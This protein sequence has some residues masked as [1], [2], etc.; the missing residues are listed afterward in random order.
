MLASGADAD[1]ERIARGFERLAARDQLGHRPPLGAPPI[2]PVDHRT[3]R[4]HGARPHLARHRAFEEFGTLPGPLVLVDM[5]IGAEGDEGARVVGHPLGDV[6]VQVQGHDDRN[7]GP[8]PGAQACQQFALAV[9]VAGDD[10][11]AVQVQQ[12]AVDR[13]L[14]LGRV[15]DHAA[16][17]V[18]R[19]VG[20]DARRVGVGRDRVNQGPAIFVGRL[21]GRPQRRSGAAERRRDLVVA[22]EVA[23]PPQRHV[24]RL[25][26][27]RIGLV[28]E[29]AGQNALHGTHLLYCARF[30]PR[31]GLADDVQERPRRHFERRGEGALLDRDE[32][33]ANNRRHREDR[34]GGDL[35]ARHLQ[36]YGGDGDL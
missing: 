27:E 34:Q 12:H 24:G 1:R 7:L 36:M 14:V 25:H 22:V 15:E 6:G 8:E 35:R 31:G 3:P 21:E 18:K 28:H 23:A 13:A 9:L 2:E 17:L 29:P 10:H 26:A 33:K 19:V 20:D 4:D 32:A 30:L 16:D 11:R 5:R